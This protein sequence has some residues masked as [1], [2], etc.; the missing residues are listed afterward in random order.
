M[1][2]K[3]SDVETR[4]S[5]RSTAQRFHAGDDLDNGRLAQKR[6]KI[7]EGAIRAFLSQGYSVS[8]DTIAQESGVAKQTIYSY[9]KDKQTLFS[10]LMDRLFEGFVTAGMTPDLLALDTRS[11]LR[12]IAH[13]TL[14]RMDDWEYVSLLRLVIAESARFPELAELYTSRV[15]RP[16]IENLTEY[17][18]TN[19]KL[20]F[21]DAE[22]TAR[23]IH[24][25]LVHFI[26]VQELLEGKHNVPL[27]RERLVNSLVDMVIFAAEKARESR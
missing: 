16:A 13:I 14:S 9:F 8:M 6:E 5:E 19:P 24:G 3:R 11:L 17:I 1:A 2:G 26:V 18:R 22:A 25:A 27:S 15:V 12:K 4:K 23:V 7:L 20:P 10:A 21:A